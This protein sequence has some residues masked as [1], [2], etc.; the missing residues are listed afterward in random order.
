MKRVIAILVLLF[1]GV[2]AMQAQDVSG[3]WQGTLNTG[4]G[5]LRLVLHI[6]KAADGTLKATMDSVDQGANGIPIK[7]IALQNS[8][9]NLDVQAVHGTYEGTVNQRCD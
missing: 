7:S 2:C 4:L 6:T 8:K 5:E 3:D 1:A 9:L